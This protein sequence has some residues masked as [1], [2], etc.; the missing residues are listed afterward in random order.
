MK[1]TIISL[2]FF[3]RPK[4]ETK[5]ARSSK[6]IVDFVTLHQNRI[7]KAKM[8]PRL[9]HFLTPFHSML[10]EEDFL[11]TKGIGFVLSF[12]SAALSRTRVAAVKRRLYREALNPVSFFDRVSTKSLELT[13]N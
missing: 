7:V 12:T 5:K 3:V 13:A 4:N 2:S 10:P 8:A 9:R 1:E 11:S 6:C